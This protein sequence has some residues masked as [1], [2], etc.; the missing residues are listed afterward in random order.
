MPKYIAYKDP[1]GK[2]YIMTFPSDRDQ[3]QHRDIANAMGFE[4]EDI[5]GAGQ[6]ID[7]GGRIVFG[8]DSLTLDIKSRGDIDKALYIEQSRR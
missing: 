6:Y 3:P 2:E 4:K 5:L 1:S 7:V 8:G